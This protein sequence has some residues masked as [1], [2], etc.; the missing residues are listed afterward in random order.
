[1]VNHKLA[2]EGKADSLL[3]PFTDQRFC[4]VHVNIRVIFGKL[5]IPHFVWKWA[6][7]GRRLADNKWGH[8]VHKP[9]IEMATAN[10]N[11]DVRSRLFELLTCQVE[12]FK[13]CANT[14]IN[15]SGSCRKNT[16]RN[17]L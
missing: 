13:G 4:Q 1:M 8:N 11:Q 5:V 2:R 3:E 6:V 10:H 9:L 7:C 12:I 16:G 14:W 17:G 15:Q